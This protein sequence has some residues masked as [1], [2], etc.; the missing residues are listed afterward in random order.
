MPDE[1]G[2]R[3]PSGTIVVRVMV[4]AVRLRGGRQ[5]RRDRWWGVEN[6]PDFDIFRR[7]W[8]RK[9]KGETLQ[10][11]FVNRQEAEEAYKAWEDSGKPQVK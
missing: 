6:K 7:W 4:L 5:R 3:Q 2:D 8:H 10:R 11:D 9:G 1:P